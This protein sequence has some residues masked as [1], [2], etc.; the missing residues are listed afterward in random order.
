MRTAGPLAV[1][2][3]AALFGTTGTAQALGPAGTTP[4]AVGAARLV[5]GGLGLLAL[6]P[7]MGARFGDVLALWRTRAGLVAGVCTAA[8]QLC[9]FVAVGQTGVAVGTL[10]TIGSGPVLAGVLALVLL[11]ERPT[12]AWLVATGVCVSGLVLLVGGGESS[13]AF[14]VTGVAAALVAAAAYAGYTVLAKQQ[15]REGHT[16]VTVMA[17]AFGLGG[18]LLVPVLLAL[19]TDW[20]AGARGMGLALYLG[21]VTTTTGYVLFARGLATLPTASVATLM[22]AEPLVAT[23]LG[24]AVLEEHLG[25]TGAAGLVVLLLGLL[26]QGADARSLTL[27][28]RRRPSVALASATSAGP[29]AGRC[30]PGAARGPLPSPRRAGWWS[31]EG[32]R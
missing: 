4:L 13:A 15:L 2:L 10:V 29:R 20:L 12:R 11:G 5:V 21:L 3:A 19:P 32:R 24:I 23:A 18:A 16:P 27:P 9:F 31:G 7:L 26:M 8:Y 25:F 14:S 6:L 22:L 28:R 17:G 30:R 1:L